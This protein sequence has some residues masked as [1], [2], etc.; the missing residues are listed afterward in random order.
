[1]RGADSSLDQGSQLA[2][3]LR[4]QFAHRAQEHRLRGEGG[5]AKAW[6]FG[7]TVNSK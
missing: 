2:E 4:K 6:P 5:L 1:M 7:V 3:T